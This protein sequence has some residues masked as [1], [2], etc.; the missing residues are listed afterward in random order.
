MLSLIADVVV[1]TFTNV[2]VRAGLGQQRLTHPG[3]V[4]RYFEEL[5]KKLNVL[6][7]LFPGQWPSPLPAASA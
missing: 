2:F 7:G 6:V 5:N 3:Y 1:I 4:E